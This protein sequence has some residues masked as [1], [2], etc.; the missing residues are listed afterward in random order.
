VV[1]TETIILV[2]NCKRWNFDVS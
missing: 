1:I 2:R